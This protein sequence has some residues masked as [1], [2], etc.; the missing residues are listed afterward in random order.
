MG[1]I[2]GKSGTF[3]FPKLFFE[4]CKSMKDSITNHQHRVP[5][6]RGV[7]KSKY[8]WTGW[9]GDGGK[10]ADSQAK[11]TFQHFEIANCM[12][13]SGSL[14]FPQF[15]RVGHASLDLGLNV[16][17]TDHT[18]QTVPN[19]RMDGFPKVSF[20]FWQTQ[21]THT[22][23]PNRACSMGFW[24]VK[25]LVS[26]RRPRAPRGRRQMLLKPLVLQHLQKQSCCGC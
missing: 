6:A 9:E 5:T 24:R 3:G 19:L 2:F 17:N 10:S 26:E 15:R 20:E 16:T 18:G 1:V 13:C 8:T 22:N 11:Q 25:G 4:D 12:L 23:S 7:F 21:R 14:A